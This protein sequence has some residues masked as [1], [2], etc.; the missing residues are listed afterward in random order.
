MPGPLPTY[1]PDF[2]AAFIGQCQQLVT[3][4]TV[5]YQLRQRASLVLLLHG[6]PLLSHGE[7]AAH[8]GL[9]PDS[10]RHWR[11]R[12]AKG[13]FCL[14]DEPGRGCHPRF[15]PAGP[16][17]GQGGR[18]RTGGRNQ[19][20]LSRQSLA[21]VTA[22]AQKALGQPISRSTVWRILATDAIK[23]WRYKY[24]IFPRDPLF[25]EKAGPILDLYAGTWQGMPLGP[26]DHILSADEKTSIQARIRCH[27]GLEPAPARRQRVEFEYDRGG[28][29]QYLAAWDVRRGYV[30]GRCEPTTGIE[31]F[32]R[33]VDQVLVQE[34]YHSAARLFWIVDNGSS[35]RGETAKPRLCQVDSRI[36][37]VHTPV[38]QTPRGAFGGPM[39]S[40]AGGGL[41]PSPHPEQHRREPQDHQQECVRSRSGI[42]SRSP[43]RLVKRRYATWFSAVAIIRRIEGHDLAFG[44]QGIVVLIL[45]F[46]AGSSGLHD[47]LH[48]CV[49]QVVLCRKGIAIQDGT[50]GFF[51][52][53]EFILIDPYGVLALAQGDGVGIPIGMDGVKAPILAANGELLKSSSSFDPS[54]PL[55]Q[56]CVRLW[57]ADQDEVAAVV[58]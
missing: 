58:K 42:I 24:W 25:A 3:R 47:G 39:V 34:P 36:V 44:F 4:R 26:K 18:L 38:H 28:A 13:D 8:V 20:A 31:P 56:R 30:M 22:R 19:T 57:L 10:V 46:P 16:C 2:P 49:I 15:S 9:H 7:A 12:W 48:A 21:D 35:H 54:Q 14:H 17:V 32:G 6:Q 50:I 55:V 1:R 40:L 11:Q 41:A 23:P 5:R 27:P 33:L 52:D 53:S 43:S 37:V 29:L 45:N 51:G